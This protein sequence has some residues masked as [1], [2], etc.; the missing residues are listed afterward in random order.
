[1]RDYIL[2][3]IICFVVLILSFRYYYIF[4]QNTE[5]FETN[6]LP[7]FQTNLKMIPT[8]F[9]NYWGNFNR[10]TL[11]QGD[12][13][14]GEN[15]L[16]I[17]ISQRN[18]NTLHKY[19]INQLMKKIILYTTQQFNLIDI[20][21]QND[22]QIL[23][24]LNKNKLNYGLV[25]SPV[26]RDYLITR[27]Q[28][29]N[30]NL[31]FMTSLTY[32]F[33]YGITYDNTKIYTLYDLKDSVIGI[34]KN[35]ATERL[36]M[37]DFIEHLNDNLKDK[38]Q[39]RECHNLEMMNLLSKGIIDFFLII[40]EFPSD[41]I[42]NLLS[43]Y[44]KARLVDMGLKDNDDFINKY[45]YERV[46]LNQKLLEYYQKDVYSNQAHGIGRYLPLDNP[47]TSSNDNNPYITSYKFPNYLL[48][49]TSNRVKGNYQ[50][51][52]EVF[53]RLSNNRRFGDNNLPSVRLQR[54]IQ[55]GKTNLPIPMHPD[56]MDFHNRVETLPQFI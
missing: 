45:P 25:S 12:I 13:E 27:N 49:N 30:T 7:F 8:V 40:G 2:S 15:T 17:G 9:Y 54:H 44:P 36:V 53:R 48:T 10:D 51:I 21:Y 20:D 24:D 34:S 50:M 14:D 4:T 16:K 47:F 41:I 23:F 33:I 46:L 38:Y 35:I 5:H 1:M 31:E 19:V 11:L 29:N 43:K 32:N 56:V 18:K 6:F 39:L 28:A 55:P 22:Y 3:F 42:R 37:K 52:R 26:L